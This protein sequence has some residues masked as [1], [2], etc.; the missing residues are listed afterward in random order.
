MM[1]IAARKMSRAS[2]SP[3]ISSNFPW[4]NE[5]AASG[6]SA[7]FR[8]EK[9][10]IT[11]AIRSMEEWMASEMMLTEPIANPTTNFISTR[12]V[13]ERTESRAVFCLSRSSDF[14]SRVGLM[15]CWIYVDRNSHQ[16][17]EH[18]RMPEV[19]SGVPV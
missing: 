9:N 14:L 7:D 16:D 15:V 12:P 13:L 17:M 1:R 8:T 6:G 2:M 5:W 18:G 10:A 4:P 19:R 11:E 3:E